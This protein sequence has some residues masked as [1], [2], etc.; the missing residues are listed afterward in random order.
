VVGDAYQCESCER[1]RKHR[2]KA[3]ACAIT[4]DEELEH[5]SEESVT[6]K[7]FN[8][9]KEIVRDLAEAQKHTELEIQKLTGRM[10]AFEVRLEGISS[11]VGYGLENSSYK[12]LP[13]LLL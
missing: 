10:D 13:S 8:E 7:E 3:Q 2:T 4:P 1:A 5:Q 11:S 6:K 9:L 12:A